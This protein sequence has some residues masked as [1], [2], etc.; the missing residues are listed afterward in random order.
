MCAALF[1][2][3]IDEQWTSGGRRGDANNWP[4]KGNIVGITTSQGVR[5][6][7]KED[8]ILFPLVFDSSFVNTL[9]H[10]IDPRVY[11]VVNV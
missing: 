7:K 1:A 9:P 6:K 4:F 5:K 11:Y 8:R 2:Q 10:T 3:R